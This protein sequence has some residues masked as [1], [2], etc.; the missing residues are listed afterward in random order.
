V[1]NSQDWDRLHGEYYAGDI[2]AELPIAVLTGAAE[3]L[4]WFRKAH[5]ALFEVLVPAGIDIHGRT[6]VAD[7]NVRFI[8]WGDTDFV[9]GLRPAHAGDVVDVPMRATYRLN[10]ADRVERLDVTFTGPPAVTRL[11]AGS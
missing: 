9:P 11:G 2:R 1:F 10:D 3:S 8:A 7:L 5:E 4:A 6:V